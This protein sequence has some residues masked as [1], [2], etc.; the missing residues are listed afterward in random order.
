MQAEI[1]TIGDE[2]L[3]GQIVDT[4]SAFIAKELNKIG[5]SVYQ[6]TS[7]QDDHDHIW[8]A[9]EEAGK[10][11]S[12]VII[13]GGLGPTKDDITKKTLCE[14]MGDHLVMDAM[15]MEHIE[16]LF[17]KYISTPISDLN[18]EQALVP[19]KATVLHNAYGSAPGLWMKNGN[20]AYVSL[21]GVPFEM[22]NLILK[23]VLPKIIEDYDRPYIVHR[24][25]M[26]YGLGESAI[27]EKI[28]EWE[29]NLP[30][31]IKLA[32]LPNLGKVRLRL[33]AKGTDKELLINGIDTATKQLYP[34]IGDIIYGVEEDESIENQI[35]KML[36]RKK[37][38]LAT[39]ESFTGGK[40]AEQLTAIPG[41]S[42]YFK[43]SVVTYA[44]E[45]KMKLLGVPKGLIEKHSV[46]S[47]EVAK[48]MALNAKN[49]LNTD[50][51]IATTGNAGPTKGD[52]DMEVGTIYIGISTPE[53]TF[54]QQFVMGK[55]RERI[56]Q[57]SVHK[58][59]ELLL[60][61]ILNF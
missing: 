53:H 39:A 44:T 19:S 24:T 60:K 13:T 25:I 17:K 6:I 23:S 28:E 2:I 32:Y 26:T 16:E 22:K 45:T 10:R 61:E 12:V 3:I 58:A 14:F 29:N 34:L 52:S 54:A 43:G 56:V 42:N 46:V 48:A 37:M 20:T 11:S 9:L 5:V 30:P 4:N 35:A 33:T 57:K 38:T 40:I 8:N 55:H 7:V 15:V 27:A 36:T 31:F 59:L 18:R 51:A 41:A 1:I 21:P 50:F 47:E 49:L